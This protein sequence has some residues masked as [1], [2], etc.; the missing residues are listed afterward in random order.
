MHIVDKVYP[1]VGLGEGSSKQHI[2]LDRAGIILLG[3]EKYNK[4]INTDREGNRSLP[5]GWEHKVA[6][7]DYECWI[8]KVVE[9][10]GGQITLYEVEEANP[11]L[12]SMLKPDV[13]CLIKYNGKGFLF[14][15]EVDMGTEDVPYIKNKINSYVDY[16]ASKQ[17]TKRQ[18]AKLFK[19]PTFP[20]VLFFTENG[21]TK[22]INSLEEY[23][24]D[25]SVRFIFGYHNNFREKLIDILKG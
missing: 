13:M 22:R 6:L 14:F 18:W 16:Y 8:R 2:C 24:K 21:R 15:I 25:M 1:S 11:Y 23:T 3:L 17:W 19:T 5:L 10:L 12:D 20:R 7:N 9:E 4:P